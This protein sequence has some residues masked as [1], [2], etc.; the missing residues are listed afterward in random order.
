MAKALSPDSVSGSADAMNSPTLTG[1]ATQIGV[2]LGTAAYM[3]PEQAKGKPVDRR[4]DIWAFGIV[5]YEMLTGKRGYHAEDVSDT[6]AAVLTREVDWTVLPVGTPPRLRTLLRDC[7]ARDPKQRLRDIGEARRVFDQLISGTPDSDD[8]AKSTKLA[9]SAQQTQPALPW[10]IAALAVVAAVTF[11]T[12]ALFLWRGSANALRPPEARLQI[13]MPGESNV[14][15]LS[16]DGR[17][18]VFTAPSENGNGYQLWLRPLDS[19]VAKPLAGT[20]SGFDC[21][22][23]SASSTTPRAKSVSI[24]TSRCNKVFALCFNPSV[25]W[26]QPAPW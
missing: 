6:L 26:V 4:A 7:L 13:L 18:L 16:P 17:Q 3:A 1:R 12:V 5:L 22:F 9:A 25:A 19:E 10:T 14:I 24:P 15:A 20:E 23:R 8:S 21:H 11:G 2:I